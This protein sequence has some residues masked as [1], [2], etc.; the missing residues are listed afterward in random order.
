MKSY[1]T[2]EVRFILPDRYVDRS[3]TGFVIPGGGPNDP[4][5]PEEPGE[6]S[7][8]LTREAVPAGTSVSDLV[9]RQLD[10]MEQVLSE[11]RLRDRASTRIDDQPA[12]RFEFTWRT[13]GQLMRQQQTYFLTDGVAVTVTGTALE[14]LFEKHRHILEQALAT[15][16]INQ[17]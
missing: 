16:K 11:F 17:P 2:N 12:E 4:I 1:Y 6:F 7:L 5:N 9:H 8:V 13:E 15:M 10:S 14:P 3:I